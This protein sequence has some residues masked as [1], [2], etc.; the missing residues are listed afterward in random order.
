MMVTTR[1]LDQ[2]GPL[3][4]VL[5]VISDVTKRKAAERAVQE[6]SGRLLRLRD[7][8]QRRI[9]RELHDTTAQ[10]LSALGMNLALVQRESER[11]GPEARAALLEC[12]AIGD[13][14]SREVRD[15]AAL[16]HPPL[17]DE[18]GLA[19]ALRWYADSFSR[20]TGISVSVNVSPDLGRLGQDIETT[21]YRVAQECLTN[22]QRHSGSPTAE[23]RVERDEQEI[24]AELRDE[25]RG[26]SSDAL[27]RHGV[28]IPGMRERVRQLGGR[29]DIRS[30]SHGTRVIV[31]LPLGGAS[32]GGG[33]A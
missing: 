32:A 5:L 31:S 2:E 26:I 23:V 14:C 10:N 1:V 9:A 28:G 6:L 19:S 8:E 21:L 22:I 16:L 12:V 33:G 18:I 13:Q 20:R 30:D 29:L 11:L 15:V 24:R 4:M 17:L 27:A 25:G 7:E 3:N